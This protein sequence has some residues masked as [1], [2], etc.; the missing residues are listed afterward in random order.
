VDGSW[1]ADPRS[2]FGDEVAQGWGDD[3]A[4]ICYTPGTTGGPKGAMLSHRNIIETAKSA[5]RREHLA[6]S[7]E[8]VAYLPMAWIGD[9][10]FSFAQS[11]VAGFTTN[12]P[13]NPATPLS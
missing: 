6:E 12:C 8:V 9:H 2:H 13:E 5:I 3:I 7:D 4:I 10:M 11:I 1:G